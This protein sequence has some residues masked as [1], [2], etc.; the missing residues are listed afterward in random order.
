[1]ENSK[2]KNC[3][4]E[5]GQEVLIN[6]RY[7]ILELL[8]EKKI[9]IINK[10]LNLENETYCSNCG[11]KLFDNAIEKIDFEIK[12]L[13][14]FISKEIEVIPIITIN[15]PSNWEY[16]IIGIVSGQS[17][18]GTGVLTEFTS[19]FSDF[20]GVES[21]LHNEKL[22]KAEKQCFLQLRIETLNM[23]GNAIITTAVDY[24]EIGSLKG[25]LMVC[26]NGTAI[27]LNNIKGAR[28]PKS[29]KLEQVYFAN[30]RLNELEKL[31][32]D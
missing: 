4:T 9:N 14:E 23:G 17:T 28:I 24:A 5:L 1:M 11:T 31:K 20:F 8:S 12:E 7:K 10:V 26:A 21:S 32:K 6:G 22:K 19:S 15:N 25:I 13:I 16:D 2:C 18:I 27:K 29:E 3:N 30:E